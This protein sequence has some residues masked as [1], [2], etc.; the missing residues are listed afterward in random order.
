MD[1]TRREL[2]VTIADQLFV[3]L[4]VRFGGDHA[5][6]HLVSLTAAAVCEELG[7]Q[8]IAVTVDDDAECVGT[9]RSKEGIFRSF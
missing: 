1:E 3:D 8:H 9:T 6:M 2:V 5:V 4:Y 7:W